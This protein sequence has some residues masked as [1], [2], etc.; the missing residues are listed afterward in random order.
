MP[1]SLP[2]IRLLLAGLPLLLAGCGFGLVL[3]TGLGDGPGGGPGDSGTPDDTGDTDDTNG[4]GDTD[5][6]GGGGDT[7]TDTDTQDPGDDVVA[8][9]SVEPGYGTTAGGVEVTI[10]GGPFDSATRV[11]FGGTLGTVTSTSS[12]QLRVVTPATSTEGEVDVVVTTSGGSGTL[13]SGFMYFEDGTGKAGVVGA[14]YWVDQV[15]TYWSGAPQ[16]WGSAWFI[17]TP[18]TD[19]EYWELYAPSL[20]SCDSD[21][22]WNGDLYYYETGLSSVN[23]DLATG[24]TLAFTWDGTEDLAFEVADLPNN[25]YTQGQSYDLPTISPTDMPSF[26]MPDIVQAPSSFSV[27]TPSIGG[28]NPPALSRSLSLAWS[29]SGGDAMIAILELLTASGAVAETVTC[30][31]RDDGSFTVPSGTWTAWAPDRQLNVFIGR[32]K[33]GTG[34]VP[35]NNAESQFAGVYW[36]YGAGITQ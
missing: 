24:G 4:G 32:A 10:R 16:D 5:S 17:F 19:L 22:V 25:R 30:A 13:T 35:F 34:T 6:G 21:Y 28:A 2:E 27:S 26:A 36:V 31:M 14:L 3:D 9:E 23:L 18:P 29:G 15:G 20:D 7:D 8:V 11:S 1:S 33:T 12:S